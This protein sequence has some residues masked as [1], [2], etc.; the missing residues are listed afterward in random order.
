MKTPLIIIAVLLC[1][2]SARAEVIVETPTQ[3]EAP[4]PVLPEGELRVRSGIVILGKICQIMAE[5]NNNET[6]EASVPKLMQLLE[7]MQTWSQSFSNLPPLSEPEVRAYEERYLPA[8]RKINNILEAQAARIAAAEYYGSR[9]LPA[10][11]VRF[12]QLGQP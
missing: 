9:N 11:L 8:I 5:I 3:K 7:E 12:V 2:P 4:K 6:A 1:L 10:V